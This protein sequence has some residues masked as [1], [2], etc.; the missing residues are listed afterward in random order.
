MTEL[1]TPSGEAALSRRSPG[2]RTVVPR[3]SIERPGRYV[4]RGTWC[5]SRMAALAD[6]G[7]SRSI[8]AR[9]RGRAHCWRTVGGAVHA[10]APDVVGR[11]AQEVAA[12]IFELRAPRSR[13]APHIEGD[14]TT[15]SRGYRRGSR[16][17][18]ATLTSRLLRQRRCCSSSGVGSILTQTCRPER[19]SGAVSNRRPSAF[20]FEGSP[21][22]TQRNPRHPRCYVGS[23]R[24]LLPAVAVT[25]AVVCWPRGSLTG[26]WEAVRAYSGRHDQRT[27]RSRDHE[28][29]HRAALG[30]CTPTSRS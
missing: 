15:C 18:A 28:P 20:Q 24:S 23:G 13:T 9:S 12:R 16:E 21:R 17:A 8:P 4:S 11:A 22:A 1:R 19:W 27:S 30:A 6:L 5:S 14:L 29:R 7:S 25:V 2:V 3:P 26:V 10:L